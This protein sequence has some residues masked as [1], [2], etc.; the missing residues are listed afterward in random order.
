MIDV[1]PRISATRRALRFG[2]VS[3]LAGGVLWAIIVAGGGG[4][5]YDILMASG[6]AA[7]MWGTIGVLIGI[8]GRQMDVTPTLD[9]VPPQISPLALIGRAFYLIVVG[10]LIGFVFASVVAAILIYALFAIE[11]DFTG[12]P[13]VRTGPPHTAVLYLIAAMSGGEAA[14]MTGAIVGACLGPSVRGRHRFLV[15]RTS[16]LGSGLSTVLGLLFG[17]QPLALFAYTSETATLIPAL[18]LAGGVFAG[19]AGALLAW[20]WMRRQAALDHEFAPASI[21]D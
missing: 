7:A 16:A 12:P 9:Q 8:F 5:A 3:L 10:F 15:F 11:D 21:T 6:I 17:M 4:S 18:S 13:R 14:A 19:I 20:I 1:T 2:G